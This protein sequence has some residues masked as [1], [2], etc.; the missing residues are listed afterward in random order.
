MTGKHL[1]RN[2]DGIGGNPSSKA[3]WLDGVSKNDVKRRAFEAGQSRYHPHRSQYTES[4]DFMIPSVS[5]KS[6]LC[7]SK[8]LTKKG[9]DLE[10][11]LEGK[12]IYLKYRYKTRCNASLNKYCLSIVLFLFTLFSTANSRKNVVFHNDMRIYSI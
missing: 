7:L 10:I 11:A 2:V 1:K 8:K 12:M 3:R 4:N 5:M 9:G 6:S